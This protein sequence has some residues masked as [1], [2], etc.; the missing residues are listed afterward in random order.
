MK[1]INR[2]NISEYQAPQE[3]LRDVL[4]FRKESEAEFSIS[5]ATQNL[6]RI[7][8]TLVS[9]IIQGKRKI[10]FDRVDELAKLMNLN[11]QEKV[12]FKNWIESAN[13]K[14]PEFQDKISPSS[15]R[16]E[17][18]THI[19]NDWLNV[20]VKDAFQIPAIQKNPDLLY[21]YFAGIANK[22]RLDKSLQFLLR[23]GHLR[24]TMDNKIVVETNLALIANSPLPVKK[25]RQFHKNALVL[26][27]NALDL[28]SPQERFAST[29]V[30]P[31]REEKYAEALEVIKEFSNRM[32]QLA[33]N[34][35]STA[36]RLYQFTLNLSPIGGKPK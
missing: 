18:S 21:V 14:M 10:T 8:P 22:S 34:N 7:S 33:E 27:K 9:L 24:K 11:F 13:P 28:F 1:E 2:P 15:N 12:Y 23:E 35:D 31:M 19:L 16:K 4:K 5:K 20:Y 17:I 30:I 29:L 3:Y 36:E 26:A 25:I 6:R 32:Q